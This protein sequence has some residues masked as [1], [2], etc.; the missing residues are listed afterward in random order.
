M[1]LRPVSRQTRWSVFSRFGFL[2]ATTALLVI[3][4][5]SGGCVGLLA[6]GLWI[7]RGPNVPPKYDTMREK[8]VVV[9]CRLLDYSEY[10]HPTVP[11]DLA[12]RISFLLGQNVPKIEVI[13]QREVE[14]WVDENTW[15][16]YLE[17]GQ[18]LDADLVLGVDLG[19]FSI[20]EGTTVYQ[21]K[22]NVQLVVYDCNTGK[23]IIEE[24][25]SQTI[26]PPNSMKSTSEIQE[27]AFRREFVGVLADQ[28][29]R[30]FY[31]HDPRV[32]FAA[33]VDAMQR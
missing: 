32:E 7:W 22:A 26:Y 11:A 33:D 18:A 14:N 19:Q 16:D 28:I 8:R 24:T 13:D 29:G 9:V 6:G 25:L 20:V 5:T 12:K 1:D 4:L 27:V 17:V 15:D 23:R 10:R 2:A 21:G 3:V 31:A 30:Y